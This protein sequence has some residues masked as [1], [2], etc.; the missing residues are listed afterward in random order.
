MPPS[1]EDI[2]SGAE[3]GSAPQQITLAPPEQPWY[4][5]ILSS[6]FLPFAIIG[7]ICCGCCFC[8][9]P[10]TGMSWENIPFV[11][12]FLNAM[13]NIYYPIM[14][15]EMQKAGLGSYV[16]AG[17]GLGVF[18]D[19]WSIFNNP[20]LL[21][22]EPAK[23]KSVAEISD[24]GI[25]IDYMDMIPSQPFAG[26]KAAFQ[27]RIHNT[28]ADTIGAKAEFGVSNCADV[29]EKTN[30]CFTDDASS[31]D[32]LR[33]GTFYQRNSC[34]ACDWACGFAYSTGAGQAGLSDYICD[35]CCDA[36]IAEHSGDL[37]YIAYPSSD[38]AP[39]DHRIY[40]GATMYAEARSTTY[41]TTEVCTNQQVA[42]H[43]G[44]IEGV[45]M[46][47][48]APLTDMYETYPFGDCSKSGDTY[49]CVAGDE[50]DADE[51]S[52]SRITSASGYSDL[53]GKEKEMSAYSFSLLEPGVYTEQQILDWKGRI[54]N[55]VGGGPVA[56]SV[57]QWKGEYYKGQ[58]IFIHYKFTIRNS[59]PDADETAY[60]YFDRIKIVIPN[61]LEVS[62][63]TENRVICGSEDYQNKTDGFASS[64]DPVGE[65]Q[66]EITGLKV[67]RFSISPRSGGCF[68]STTAGIGDCP[69]GD[70]G[71]PFVL[72]EGQTLE[73]PI[74]IKTT[75][76]VAGKEY[77]VSLIFQS[78]A[79]TY[80][81]DQMEVIAVQPPL[82]RTLESS[83]SHESCVDTSKVDNDGDGVYADVDLCDNAGRDKCPDL[84]NNGVY[85]SATESTVGCYGNLL[86]ECTG[87]GIDANGCPLW[88]FP[89]NNCGNYADATETDHC[90]CQEKDVSG[91]IT[92]ACWYYG[93]VSGQRTTLE[94]ATLNTATDIVEQSADQT[95]YCDTTGT[96]GLNGGC[97]GTYEVPS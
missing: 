19:L 45:F 96:A 46:Y 3:G 84:N 69:L 61:E 18:S 1:L 15:A 11:G 81:L 38:L 36:C 34:G 82:A 77:T 57:M 83:M 49:S 60:L 58:N 93:L 97:A 51:V 70:S 30:L 87:V 88:T 66:G 41:A 4:K 62:T 27:M 68:W 50:S 9:G 2:A 86:Y 89:S 53:A 12:P 17:A 33:G 16:Q 80:R 44:N 72:V 92:P 25:V 74:E 43:S 59:D 7:I 75:G 13:A 79:Y 5:K 73:I 42:S 95:L 24:V 20:W 26:Q 28:M 90:F 91:T 21:E 29:F 8:G 35:D 22:W 54:V 14:R 67:C 56:V 94:C 63:G 55:Y 37:G 52:N 10:M 6:K 85:D 65:T 40:P 31:A 76:A 39:S 71:E 78:G 32:A 23:T 64:V 48:F 47:D